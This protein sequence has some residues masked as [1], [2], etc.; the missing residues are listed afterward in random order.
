[1]S[2]PQAGRNQQRPRDRRLLGRGVSSVPSDAR[3]SVKVRDGR[4]PAPVAEGGGDGA[5]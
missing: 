1:M 5:G 4:K 3:N 2:F